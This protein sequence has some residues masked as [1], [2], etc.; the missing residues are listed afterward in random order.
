MYQIANVYA[1]VLQPEES[2]A[3]VVSKA[4]Q[5]G[6]SAA[7]LEMQAPYPHLHDSTVLKP[8]WPS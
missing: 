3:A 4:Q 2:F 6:R 5:A 1:G 8:Q 7:P